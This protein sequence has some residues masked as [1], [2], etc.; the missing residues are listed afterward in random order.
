MMFLAD[1]AFNRALGS[2]SIASCTVLVSTQSVFVF[3]FAVL[4]KVEKFF[5]IKLFGVVLGIAGTALTAWQD[6]S[7]DET[8]SDGKS[9]LLGDVCAILAA[10]GYATY[11]VQVRLL[12]P[13]DE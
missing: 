11:T 4:A 12:C 9:A 7:N 2:T 1:Y 6:I 10:V 5:W 13:Q 3:L 8:D